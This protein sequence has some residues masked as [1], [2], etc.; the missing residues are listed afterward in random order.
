[1]I[2]PVVSS[3]MTTE[4]NG[5]TISNTPISIIRE[6]RKHER[7]HYVIHVINFVVLNAFK[8]KRIEGNIQVYNSCIIINDKRFSNTLF[9]Q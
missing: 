2:G 4:Q 8:V 3:L 5:R 9:M 6:K 7:L 1:M